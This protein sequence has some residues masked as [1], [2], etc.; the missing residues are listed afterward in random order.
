MGWSFAAGLSAE[1]FLRRRARISLCREVNQSSGTG[2]GGD[3][4]CGLL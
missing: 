2:A 4:R 1:M 3:T